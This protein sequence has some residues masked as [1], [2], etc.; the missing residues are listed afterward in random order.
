MLSCNGK[1]AISSDH[2]VCNLMS[3][4][5]DLVWAVSSVRKCISCVPYP[6]KDDVMGLDI[7]RGVSYPTR[8]LNKYFRAGR[9]V[10]YLC[11]K[12]QSGLL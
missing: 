5:L 12:F 4:L 7:V 9:V 10:R 8:F 3:S 2:H 6:F 11:A 1:N